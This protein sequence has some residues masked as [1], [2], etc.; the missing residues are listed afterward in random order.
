MISTLKE[1][2]NHFQV[3]LNERGIVIDKIE[4]QVKPGNSLIYTTTNEIYHLKYTKNAFRPDP[5]KQGPA[6]EL[7]LK[8]HF[9]INTFQNRSINSLL[10]SEVGTLVGIDEDLIL[11]LIE[12]ENKGHK[13]IIV[14]VLERGI[15]LW[16]P[17]YDFYSFVMR[18]DTFIKFPRSGVPVCYAPTG[19][20]L[21]WGLPIQAYPEIMTD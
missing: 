21:A 18:Y 16:V 6:R 1:S 11:N 20:F 4:S 13:T 8:L 15:S 5:D 9:A 7:H 2:E 10:P 17:G 19:Y 14:T 3:L 12:L